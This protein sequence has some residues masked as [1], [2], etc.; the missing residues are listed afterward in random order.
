[1]GCHFHWSPLVLIR[2][3]MTVQRYVH[4]ILQPHMYPLMQQLPEAIFQQDNARPH[5]A[6]VSKTVSALLL[7]FLSLPDPQI[8][9]QS[10]ISETFWDVEL[11]IPRV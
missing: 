8:C 1:M 9:L 3:T 5:T 10:S 2:V 6:R 7:P 11:G 4:D